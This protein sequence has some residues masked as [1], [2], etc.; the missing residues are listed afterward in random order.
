MKKVLWKW[1]WLG[2]IISI[3]RLI[4]LP[5]AKVSWSCRIKKRHPSF[6]QKW[7]HIFCSNK[8]EAYSSFMVLRSKLCC[9]LKSFTSPTKSIA[10]SNTRFG[11]THCDANDEWL[12]HR[13]A[14]GVPLNTVM[15]PIMKRRRSFSNVTSPKEVKKTTKYCL[16]TQNQ[17]MDGVLETQLYKVHIRHHSYL[18]LETIHNSTR[19]N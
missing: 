14:I 19:K 9:L 6:Q 12:D 13:S 1:R 3:W 17:D 5:A 11:R 18:V 4:Q 8:H 2:L 10:V 15:Q 7:V 16:M